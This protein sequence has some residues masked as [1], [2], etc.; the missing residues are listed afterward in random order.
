MF[1]DAPGE[2]KDEAD[3]IDEGDILLASASSLAAGHV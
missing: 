1:S 3:R 2:C